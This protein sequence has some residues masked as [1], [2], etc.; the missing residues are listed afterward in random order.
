MSVKP[1]KEEATLPPADLPVEAP[2]PFWAAA[3]LDAGAAADGAD[4]A[5]E[6]SDEPP[7]MET[8]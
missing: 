4:A 3:A 2:Y 7:L 1:G 8:M 5:D 6:L